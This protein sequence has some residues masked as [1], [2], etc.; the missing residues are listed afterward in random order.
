MESIDDFFKQI[1]GNLPYVLRGELD[2]GSDIEQRLVMISHQ[3]VKIFDN[4]MMNLGG[5]EEAI[6]LLSILRQYRAF[7]AAYSG[8]KTYHQLARL[9]YALMSGRS[10]LGHP[11][12]ADGYKKVI[13]TLGKKENPS[14]LLLGFSTIY[15]LENLAALMSLQG[16]KNPRI[17]AFDFSQEPLVEAQKYC[18]SELYGSDILY[19]NGDALDPENFDR[20]NFDMIATHLFFTHIKHKDKRSLIENLHKWLKPGAVF[21]DEEII[22]PGDIDRV[23]YAEYYRTLAEHHLLSDHLVTRRQ[24]ADMMAQFGRHSRFFPYGSLD[25]L[26]REFRQSGLDIDTELITYRNMLDDGGDVMSCPVYNVR[27]TKKL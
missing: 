6:R 16:I 24:I 19:K 20:D 25:K 1:E 23:R 11:G 9:Y 4:G 26:T 27:A 17:T 13:E 2:L 7:H 8:E 3:K 18:G 10:T 5:S 21:V 12:D 15:S 22:V 14:V